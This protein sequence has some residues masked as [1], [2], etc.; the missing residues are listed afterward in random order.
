MGFFGTR[1]KKLR[2]HEIPV[3]NYYCYLL[4]C[5]KVRDF[6]AYRPTIIQVYSIGMYAEI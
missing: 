3:F 6:G 2:L 1:S 4:Y 5:I